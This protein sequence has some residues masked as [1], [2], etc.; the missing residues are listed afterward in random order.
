MLAACVMRGSSYRDAAWDIQ[1]GD[2]IVRRGFVTTPTSTTVTGVISE[3][4]ES[5]SRPEG[6]WRYEIRDLTA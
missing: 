3:P 6:W 4:R 5:C 2:A 1:N